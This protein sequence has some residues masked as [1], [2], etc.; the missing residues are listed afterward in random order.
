MAKESHLGIYQERAE[1]DT[2]QLFFS[3]SS[4][5]GKTVSGEPKSTGKGS[6][7][8]YFLVKTISLFYHDY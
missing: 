7:G 5:N 4:V 2:E 8:A 3:V 6:A 1:A